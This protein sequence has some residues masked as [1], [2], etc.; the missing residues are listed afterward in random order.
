MTI[1]DDIDKKVSTIKMQNWAHF[2][3]FVTKLE[4]NLDKVLKDLDD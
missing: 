2:K 4:K 1:L 3:G